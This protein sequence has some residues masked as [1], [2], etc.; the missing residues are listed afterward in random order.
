MRL[1]RFPLGLGLGVAMLAAA[2]GVP[3]QTDEELKNLQR[4]IETL[5]DGQAA[6]VKQLQELQDLLRARGGGAPSP[7]ARAP[8]SVQDAPFKGDK[9]AAVTMVEFSDYEC[10]FCGRYFRDTLA[11]IE[12]DYIK[13]GKI[14]YVFRDFPI[15]SIHP[16]AFKA[17]AAAHCAGEQ[18]RYWEMHDRLFSHQSALDRDHLS[19]HAKALA[20][21]LPGF[22]Q[23]LDS[24]R[25][26]ALIRKSLAEGQQAGVR[27]T[28]TFFLGPTDAQGASLNAPVTIV[29]AQPYA[30]F[31]QALDR[32][33][34]GAK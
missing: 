15:E 18:G 34:S 5:K 26:A 27:G 19:G 4:E 10:P 31:K 21:D 12:R 2:A 22:E 33:L 16:K 28:P 29:G 20:L 30:S 32:L 3:A 24:D 7:Q 8:I 25:H 6:I 14:K 17:A 23:C 11:E 1:R 9:S 13:T